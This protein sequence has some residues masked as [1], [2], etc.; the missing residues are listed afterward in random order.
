MSPIV[1]SR[2]DEQ[3]DLKYPKGQSSEEE[4]VLKTALAIAVFAS[5]LFILATAGCGGKLAN[6]GWTTVTE[7][8]DH[9]LMRLD[10]PDGKVAWKRLDPD[11]MPQ[12]GRL[13]E[14]NRFKPAKFVETK[15]GSTLTFRD[16]ATVI[17]HDLP[18]E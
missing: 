14:K 11:S 2:G 1:S 6:S 16:G 17:Y 10:Y 18:K 7:V 12:A 4:V 5:V 13:A 15:K 8:R 9:G 3:V